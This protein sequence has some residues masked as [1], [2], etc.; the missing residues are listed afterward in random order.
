[1]TVTGPGDIQR[2]GAQQF[3]PLGLRFMTAT[4][5]IS[6]PATVTEFVD[7]IATI[8]PDEADI[9]GRAWAELTVPTTGDSPWEN[10]HRAAYMASSARRTRETVP[11]AKLAV[12]KAFP[13]Y[14]T[15][16]HAAAISGTVHALALSGKFDTHFGLR[17]FRVLIGPA[18]EAGLLNADG[19]IC[20]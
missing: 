15:N 14:R 2:F 9:L 16:T 3:N 10:A 17:H 12:L 13:R 4:I 20:N 1:M 8:T 7:R 18:V 19:T 5:A 6:S 11:A